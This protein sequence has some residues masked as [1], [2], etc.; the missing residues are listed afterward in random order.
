M[1]EHADLI[2]TNARILTMDEGNPRAEAIAIADGDDPRGR[3]REIDRRAQGAGDQDHRCRRQHG[4][5][6]LHRSAYASVRRR[7]RTDASATFG[8]AGFDA[9]HE[10]VRAYAAARPGRQLLLAQGAD[11]TILSA[12]TSRVTRHHLDR[13][14]ADRP[15]A[16]SAP[17][18]H[19]MWANTMALELAGAAARQDSSAPATRS[20]WVPTGWRQA[21]CARARRS[22]RCS[23]W[24]A[25][26]AC[27]SAGDRRR[28]RSAPR[29]RRN[30]RMTAP[31]CS[32]GWNG[33]PAMASPR[34][35]TWTATST[36]SSCC[37]RSR[38]RASCSAACRSRST[39]RTS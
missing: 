17:D 27:G 12:R 23:S 24:P 3:R 5:A 33:A 4:R 22:G 26:A 30:G 28:A 14:I 11:Y 15:F 9:L 6:R 34:S 18:H 16:M 8:R 31:S 2:V 38:P 13:I 37:R 7:S 20:S 36:S 32:A 25:R 1:P 35:R 19:T 39:S 10:A 29:R 21:S